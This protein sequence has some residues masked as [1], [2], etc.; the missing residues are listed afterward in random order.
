MDGR[1]VNSYAAPP[2]IPFSE[3]LEDDHAIA[4]GTHTL[5][6][7]AR[8]GEGWLERDFEVEYA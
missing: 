7:R 2:Y 6:V 1:L 4:A 3:A 5:R 8:D